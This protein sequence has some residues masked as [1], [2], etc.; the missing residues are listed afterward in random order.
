MEL[1]GLYWMI[2][3][4][5]CVVENFISYCF[6]DCTSIHCTFLKHACKTWPKLAYL[7]NV[8]HIFGIFGIFLI[9]S[10]LRL[11]IWEYIWCTWLLCISYKIEKSINFLNEN[12]ALSPKTISFM[13]KLL[14]GPMINIMIIRIQISLNHI[15][16]KLSLT[17][18]SAIVSYF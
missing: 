5:L 18:F 6:Q 1:V 9:G 3:N 10:N 14:H 7:E 12:H 15:S 4:L 2:K 11:L 8:P 16:V 13:Y 17:N